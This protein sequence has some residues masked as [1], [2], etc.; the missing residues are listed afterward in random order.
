MSNYIIKVK[1][2]YEVGSGFIYSQESVCEDV[3]VITARHVLCGKDNEHDIS[4]LNIEISNQDFTCQITS[5]SK[6]FI[7]EDNE[8]EDI[9]IITVPKNQLDI[10][11]VNVK[12]CCITKEN[13]KCYISGTSNATNTE[14]FRTLYDCK[15]LD[16]RDNANQIQL[17]C[18]DT[19]VDSNWNSKDLVGGYSGSGAFLKINDETFI[20]GVVNSFDQNFM[21]FGC[22][23]IVLVNSILEKNGFSPIVIQ[24][25]ET[26]EGI[27]QD[28]KKLQNHRDITLNRV[29][30]VINKTHLSRVKLKTDIS[31]LI[32][33]SQ[34]LLVAGV[35]GVGKSALIKNILT[36]SVETEIIAFKADELDRSSCCE[37]LKSIGILSELDILLSSNGL[38]KR[39]II[40]ID[41]AEKILEAKY[42]DTIIDF[43]SAINSRDD[44]KIIFTLRSHALQFLRMRLGSI[45][46][47]SSFEIN[48][49]END[50]LQEIA[51]IHPHIKPLIQNPSIS[52][53]LSNPFYLART[54]EINDPQFEKGI[55]DEKDLKQKLWVYLVKGIYYGFDITTQ[56]QRS[57][58]FSEIS[59]NRAKTMTAFVPY[60]D[61]SSIIEKLINENLIVADELNENFAPAHDIFEDWALTKFISDC[62]E[63]KITQSQSTDSFYFAIGNEPSIRRSFRLFIKE[64]IDNKDNRID[65]F[66]SETLVSEVFQYWKDEI[67]LAVLQANSSVNFL[68]INKETLFRNK[69]E[70]FNRYMLLL[71]VACQQV[72]YK[73]LELMS[74]STKDEY[75]LNLF[76]KPIG[77]EWYT[78]INFINNNREC[79]DGNYNNIINLL[80]DWGKCIDSNNYPL[81]AKQGGEILTY[82]INLQ[83]ESNSEIIRGTEC[84]KL[85][86]KLS[87]VI[88]EEISNLFDWSINCKKDKNLDY[89]NTHFRDLLF[90]HALSWTDSKE[91]CR[92]TPQ[93]I[94]QIAKLN[95][96]VKVR[97]LISNN[98]CFLEEEDEKVDSDKTTPSVEKQYKKKINPK[99]F[100]L[101]KKIFVKEKPKQHKFPPIPLTSLYNI[102]RQRNMEE[103]FGVTERHNYE[104]SPSSAF[105]TPIWHLLN[106]HPD[107]AIQL[108]VDVFNHSIDSLEE[109]GR[110]SEDEFITII[111]KKENDHTVQQ[112]GNQVLWLSYRGL[113]Q[114]PDILESILMAL[115]KWMIEV[116]DLAIKNPSKTNLQTNLFWMFDYLIYNSRNVSISGVLASVSTAQP[117]FWA[118]KALILL[119]T[120]KFIQW[121]LSRYSPEMGVSNIMMLNKRHLWEER[122]ISNKLPHRKKTLENV[123]MEL[124]TIGYS[125]QIYEIIDKYRAHSN[126]DYLWKLA[127][128]R[129]DFR[130]YKPIYK[131]EDR[132]YFQGEIQE[133]LKPQAEAFKTEFDT[134]KTILTTSNW[135]QRIYEQPE[136][137]PTLQE[138]MDKFNTVS[139]ST[140]ILFNSLG[141]YAVIGIRDLWSELSDEHKKWCIDTVFKIASMAIYKE[142]YDTFLQYSTSDIVPIL[143]ILPQI[144]LLDNIDYKNTAKKITFDV[145]FANKISKHDKEN[146]YNQFQT[147]LWN[148]EIEFSKACLWN[149][150]SFE[151]TENKELIYD[152]LIRDE[153]I[154]YIDNVNINNI[155]GI[156]NILS[157]VTTNTTDEN[158]DLLINRLIDVIM[159]EIQCE[160]SNYHIPRHILSFET[161]SDIA[162]WIGDYLLMQPFKKSESILKKLITRVLDK[163]EKSKHNNSRL[164]FVNY[165]LTE[166]MIFVSQHAELKDMFW[167]LWT[168]IY[169]F[170]ENKNT[171]LFSDALLLQPEKYG[172]GK[173]ENWFI[174]QGKH[175]FIQSCIKLCKSPKETLTVLTK[176]GFEEL[177]P[178]GLQWLYELDGFKIID[179]ENSFYLCEKLAQ[180]LYYSPQKRTIIKQNK[181]LTDIFIQCLDLL[182]ENGSAISFII[183]DD[184]IATH[185]N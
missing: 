153:Y 141:T 72:D 24:E 121:D 122:N 131:E 115:E 93:R 23:N 13:I 92:F 32:N 30:D 155:T 14:L 9:A 52:N 143:S 25:I 97:P 80:L 58:V 148:N 183:R 71:R 37:I 120:R 15:T 55:L 48:G 178:D 123:A 145:F 101:I 61:N 132:I 38:Q 152:R 114:T 54:V 182:I 21:R 161:K 174:I 41:S 4:L 12:L 149:V 135:S 99:I 166:M 16:D 110:F 66:I 65:S 103:E 46:S 86:Y 165:I 50:E 63:N 62:F 147:L 3:L 7:G 119:E 159:D 26:N 168:C 138:W 64:Q 96:L 160:D 43:I 44:S 104:Y 144:I 36:E 177:M 57:K 5:F 40:L 175:D 170:S 111:I 173:F 171:I 163:G 117:E 98:D 134:K 70:V 85:L 67:L 118:K 91:L 10:H 105:Q 102:P 94:V 100:N 19:L 17:L 88:Q 87:G 78:I 172:K 73:D 156:C 181:K 39:K 69:N 133:E 77:Q 76:L 29:S 167:N 53:M 83:I 140:D 124:T 136:N 49:F 75:P 20:F 28:I 142:Q 180:Q 45:I 126:N 6:V 18:K 31:E 116:T 84:I 150:V 95:W 42:I 157:V 51:E 162:E 109:S 2:Q 137:P 130:M 151:K 108:I 154:I 59:I 128:D 33:K 34:N 184:F 35:A 164:D 90:K 176:I 60:T 185:N 82:M 158:I 47:F 56:Q 1:T 89:N 179:D 146:F 106:Y 11:F 22:T 139:T 74:T 169:Q 127:L 8:T 129:M 27:L 125:K 79:I 68:S 113:S 112:K 81:E 107:I